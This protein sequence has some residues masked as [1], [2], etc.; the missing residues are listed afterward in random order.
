LSVA[1]VFVI[2]FNYRVRYPPSNRHHLSNGYCL[3]V[4]TKII[5][6]APCRVVYNSCA[7]LYALTFQ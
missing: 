5:I 1:E 4:K 7:Q 6:T 2:A 3:E